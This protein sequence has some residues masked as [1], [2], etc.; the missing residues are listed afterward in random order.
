[1]GGTTLERSVLALGRFVDLSKLFG[2][3]CY[4]GISQHRAPGVGTVGPGCDVL[5]SVHAGPGDL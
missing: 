3:T 2:E 5:C 1:M 4:V